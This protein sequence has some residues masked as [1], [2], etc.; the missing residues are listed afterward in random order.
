[1]PK[2]TIFDSFILLSSNVIENFLN[3]NTLCYYLSKNL[4]TALQK[5]G[6]SVVFTVEGGNVQKISPVI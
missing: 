2:A 6:R 3:Y 1:N 5:S 4:F